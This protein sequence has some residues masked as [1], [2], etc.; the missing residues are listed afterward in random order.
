MPR[1]EDVEVPTIQR[2]ELRLIEALDDRED[3][4]VHEPY[5]GIGVAIA[6]PPDARVVFNVQFLNLVCARDD[7]VEES[8]EHTGMQAP[9]DPVIHLDEHRS[10]DDERL[11]GPLDEGAARRMIR[12]ATVQRSVERARIEDQRHARGSARSSTVR[13]AVS[14]HPDSPIPKLR[15]T[16]R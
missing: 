9:M 5:V 7:V 10:G 4:C 16:G 12:V 1:A 6:D 3:R 11:V 14:V 8:D 13:R 2:A 15:G